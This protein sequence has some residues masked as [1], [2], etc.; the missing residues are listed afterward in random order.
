MSML[1]LGITLSYRLSTCYSGFGA[2]SES[3]SPISVLVL[4]VSRVLLLKSLKQLFPV[5]TKTYGPQTCLAAD[6]F[7]YTVTW[8]LARSQIGRTAS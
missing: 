4:S 3:C 1:Q 8:R 6:K 2:D 5:M 7:M